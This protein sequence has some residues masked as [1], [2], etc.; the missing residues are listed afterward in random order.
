MKKNHI[1]N[2]DSTVP[3]NPH[4]TAALIVRFFK[5]AWAEKNAPIIV[6]HFKDVMVNGNLKIYFPFKYSNLDY[7]YY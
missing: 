5:N 2:T 1:G 4:S 6:A 3:H 7:C